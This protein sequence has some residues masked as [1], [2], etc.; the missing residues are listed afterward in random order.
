MMDS[1]N[2]KSFSPKNDEERA[3]DEAQLDNMLLDGSGSPRNINNKKVPSPR[4]D[5]TK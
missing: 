5:M 4:K 3:N 2:N 1:D